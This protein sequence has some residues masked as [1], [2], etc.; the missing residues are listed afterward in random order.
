AVAPPTPVFQNIEKLSGDCLSVPAFAVYRSLV[1][2]GAAYQNIVGDV[3]VSK[4]GALAYLS[5]GAGDADDSLLGSPFVM[6]AAMHAACVWGQRFCD[7]VAFPAGFA[8]RTVYA[9][10]RKGGSYLGRIVPVT[11]SRQLLEFDIWIFDEQGVLCERIVS[12]Q[13]RDV[14]RGRMRPPAWIK[15]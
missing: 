1:P 4:E 3:S 12:L 10:T 7:V 15:E 11:F 14:T 5:G 13:M 9:P 6:D 2:F 8:Q